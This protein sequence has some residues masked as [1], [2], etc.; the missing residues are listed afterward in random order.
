[1]EIKSYTK[2]VLKAKNYIEVG[3]EKYEIKFHNGVKKSDIKIINCQ[4]K[5]VVHQILVEG[6]ISYTY[7]LDNQVYKIKSSFNHVQI[8]SDVLSYEYVKVKKKRII[9][10]NEEVIAQFTTPKWFTSEIDIELNDESYGDELLIILAL[11]QYQRYLDDLA[12]AATAGA[13]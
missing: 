11:Y 9:K 12:I 6:T 1:M 4:N 2:G 7:H 10:R 5:Q 8:Y 13:V 3:S